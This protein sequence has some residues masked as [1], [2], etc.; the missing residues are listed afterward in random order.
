MD[1]STLSKPRL[2]FIYTGG[3]IGM[4]PTDSGL[5][6]CQ[7]FLSA[8]MDEMPELRGGDSADYTI[9]EYSP[10]LDSA[11]F[12][13]AHWQRI[14]SDIAENYDSYDAFV[15]LHGTDTMAYTASA[16]PFMLDGLN[17]T[18]I[19]TGSQLPLCMRRNDARDN[20]ITAFILASENVIPEVCVYFG[21]RLLRGCRT[22]KV[23][24][25]SFVAFDS[26]NALPLG[27]AGT[28]I[29]VYRQRVREPDPN[30][31]LQ[32]HEIVPAQVATFRLFPGVSVEVLNNVLCTPLK[33]LVLETY[34][35]GNGPTDDPAFLRVLQQA[36]DQGIVIINRSQC[37]HGGAAVRGA[38]ETGRAMQDVG[39]ISGRDITVEAA[40][41]KL[42]YLFSQGGT[43]SQ[44]RQQMTTN[45][46]GEMSDPC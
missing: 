43:P 35:T 29:D 27:I 36:T 34:G 8:Q 41:T 4:K 21:S 39:V 38:Y 12:T 44:V 13:P 19:I 22:T 31:K 14:A 26:P 7:G 24:T 37:F 10:I 6:P 46:V 9:L 30:A 23:S 25:S 28:S 11:N 17:K 33:G 16:L 18:V 2:L 3:T 1:T 15:I 5:R 45:L 42:M 40:I 20:L 32:V